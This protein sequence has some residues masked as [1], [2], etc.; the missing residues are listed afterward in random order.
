MS[1][2]PKESARKVKEARDASLASGE[3][4]HH[5]FKLPCFES[6]K[7]K[8]IKKNP[9]VIGISVEE[10][11]MEECRKFIR[12]ML[13][14]DCASRQNSGYVTKC[15]C[16]KDIGEDD[17]DH[18]ARAMV[19]YFNMS[20]HGRYLKIQ[21]QIFRGKMAKKRQW[22]K[23]LGNKRKRKEVKRMSGKIF[24]LFYTYWKCSRNRLV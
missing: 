3:L 1:S 4:L 11:M 17:I 23:R 14:S 2:T 22:V 9:V 10:E 15:N 18:E 24:L 21:D 12:W 7:L 5:P 19:N 8:G 13:R 16:Q 20:Q 6:K